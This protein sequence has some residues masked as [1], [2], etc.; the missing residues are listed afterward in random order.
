M[1]KYKQS[2]IR[3]VIDCKN[4]VLTGSDESLYSFSFDQKDGH[5]RYKSKGNTDL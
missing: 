4:C 1:Y 2:P 3:V 5:Y